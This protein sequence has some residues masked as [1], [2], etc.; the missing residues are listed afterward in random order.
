MSK[1][2]TSIEKVS[3]RAIETAQLLITCTGLS[4]NHSSVLSTHTRQLIITSTSSSGGLD[5]IFGLSAGTAH[6]DEVTYTYF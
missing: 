3:L 6:T 2:L 5:I 1:S 4:E